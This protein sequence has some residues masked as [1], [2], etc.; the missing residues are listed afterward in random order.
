MNGD[1]FDDIPPQLEQSDTVSDITL[2]SQE[3]PNTPDEFATEPA[4]TIENLQT[5][6][7]PSESI[8][9][10]EKIK[11]TRRENPQKIKLLNYV[12]PQTNKYWHFIFKDKGLKD[13]FTQTLQNIPGY[14]LTVEYDERIDKPDIILKHNNQ[15]VGKIHLLLSD[16]RD[17]NKPED[18]YIK[19][20]LFHFKSQQLFDAVKITIVH[21]FDNLLISSK[22]RN[23]TKRNQKQS[24]SMVKRSMAKRSIYT[25]KNKRSRTHKSFQK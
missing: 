3:Y 13:K 8:A 16:R 14:S 21:F 23:S 19:I 7:I 24:R 4:T 1:E 20:Y 11:I 2:E 12:K 10:I 5:A 9:I 15:I 22:K 6:N 25:H 17:A 18:Y